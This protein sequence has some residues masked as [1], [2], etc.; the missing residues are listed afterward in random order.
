GVWSRQ[1]LHS[2]GVIKSLSNDPRFVSLNNTVVKVQVGADALLHCLTTSTT[3]GQVSWVRKRDYQLLTVGLKVHSSDDRFT[4]RYKSW[5]WQLFVR[6]VQL[7]DAGIYECQVTSHPPTSL[8]VHLHVIQPKAEIL[9]APEKHVKL[10]SMLRLVCVMHDT[11]QPPKYVYWYRD[12][13]VINYQAEKDIMVESDD[14]TSVLLISEAKVQ[15]SGNYTCAPSNVLG[16]SI[17]VH[18]LD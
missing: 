7:R 4:M 18:I 2:Q 1:L 3:G 13:E 15:Q 17:S 5:D 16:A 8:F 9:G 11:T 6:H 14:H 10:G 12:N